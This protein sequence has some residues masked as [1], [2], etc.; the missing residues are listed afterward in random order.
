MHVSESLLQPVYM[1]FPNG[2][3]VVSFTMPSGNFFKEAACISC[4]KSGD[5]LLAKSHAK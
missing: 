2:S 3:N 4:L 5:F 1:A